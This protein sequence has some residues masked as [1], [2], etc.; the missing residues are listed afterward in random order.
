MQ[1][2]ALID[3]W[4]NIYQKF[5]DWEFLIVGDGAERK[6]LE[7]QV[8]D[9]GLERVYFCGETNKPYEYYN[10]ASILCLSSQFEGIP[11]V[12]KLG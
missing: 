10:N 9:Y 12:L 11:L 1:T 4:K 3:I 2:N 7:Q 5:P 6:N 8:N